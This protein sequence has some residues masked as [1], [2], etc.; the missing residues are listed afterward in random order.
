MRHLAELNSRPGLCARVSAGLDEAIEQPT[1]IRSR[2]MQTDGQV[3]GAVGEFSVRGVSGVGRVKCVQLIPEY[4][5]V[6]AASSAT[7]LESA[8][9][10]EI[11]WYVGYLM[12]QEPYPDSK[13]G[14]FLTTSNP[15]HILPVAQER[16]GQLTQ[17]ATNSL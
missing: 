1:M 7:E 11:L 6:D 9:N 14:R 12:P 15:T 17:R 3:S 16:P 2:V 8:T 10:Q 5:P 13:T 4:F